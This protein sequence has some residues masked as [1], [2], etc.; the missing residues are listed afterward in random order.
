[1]LRKA[2]YSAPPAVS[3]RAAPNKSWVK[4]AEAPHLTAK[5]PGEA[6][7]GRA[8]DNNPC[9]EDATGTKKKH[10]F[11]TIIV[12]F[13]QPPDNIPQQPNNIPQ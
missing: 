1:M 2:G 13:P 3:F 10:N 9:P 4:E 12:Y 6:N 8:A 11:P 5:N 7:K